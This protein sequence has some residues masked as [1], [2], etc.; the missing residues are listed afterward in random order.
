M[1]KE[2]T[3]VSTP[4][5]KP[6]CISVTLHPKLLSEVRESMEREG[7]YNMSAYLAEALRQHLAAV[8]SDDLETG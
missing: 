3:K 8:R 7:Y 5:Q 2:L 6:V 4:A 1:K